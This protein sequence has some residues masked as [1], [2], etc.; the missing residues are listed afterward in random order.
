MFATL[1]ARA[2]G[3]ATRR[4]RHRKPLWSAAEFE[5]SFGPKSD[6][7][8]STVNVAML[9]GYR[10]RYSPISCWPV[11]IEFGSQFTGTT[12]RSYP[13]MRGEI[14]KAC[15]SNCSFAF[16]GKQPST[17]CLQVAEASAN[18]HFGV[19]SDPGC[20]FLTKI[21]RS[22]GPR[23][24]RYAVI[25]ENSGQKAPP[26]FRS[27]VLCTRPAA[28]IGIFFAV[29]RCHMGWIFIKIRS[30]NSKL[31]AVHVNPFPQNFA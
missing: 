12:F 5:F 30:P 28:M 27:R 21:Q 7:L 1:P 29:D 15:S 25:D 23:E 16:T 13:A 26:N 6:L 9:R 10:C 8:R 31:F 11:P 18:R 14:D 4:L 17:R 22:R 2:R 19:R 3:A 20:L 24:L